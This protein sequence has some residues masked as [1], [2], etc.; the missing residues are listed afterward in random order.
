MTKRRETRKTVDIRKLVPH[1]L[2]VNIFGLEPGAAL[3]DSVLEHGVLEDIVVAADGMTIMSG[4]RRRAA[5]MDAKQFKADVRIRDDLI[6]QLDIEESVLEYNTRA[7][8]TKEMLARSQ[9]ARV[10]IHM[11]RQKRNGTA[12]PSQIA[13]IQEIA[14]TTGVSES[15]TK[16][17]VETIAKETELRESGK[18][19]EANAV[20]KAMNDQGFTAAK[21]LATKHV[22]P[23]KRQPA[24][25]KPQ[26]SSPSDK[27]TSA[28]GKRLDKARASFEAMLRALPKKVFDSAEPHITNLKKVLDRYG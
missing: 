20:I 2:S 9:A 4:S 25:P 15:T 3:A 5:M 24:K 17:I 16:R 1:D 10:R 11:E 8:Q 21:E 27:L 14:E 7:P 22:P 6:E 12:H 23:K 26:A 18:T 28:D 13:A 19:K